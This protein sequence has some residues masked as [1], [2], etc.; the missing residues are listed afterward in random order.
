MTVNFYLSLYKALFGND[1]KEITEDQQD[2]MENA[3]ASL[4]DRERYVL[5]QRFGERCVF[6][7][8]ASDLGV[9]R[10]RVQQIQEAALKKLRRKPY[11][12]YITVGHKAYCN[13]RK[14]Y[15]EKYDLWK[16]NLSTR[17]TNCLGR[18]NIRTIKELSQLS[19]EDL[20]EMKNLGITTAEEI[21]NKLQSQNLYLK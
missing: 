13:A 4:K 5:E 14:E 2:G 20:M 17:A 21:R 10:A 11:L 3:L 15:L 18:N 19:F 8:V 1:P 9:S 7:K 6:G 12:A 16:L